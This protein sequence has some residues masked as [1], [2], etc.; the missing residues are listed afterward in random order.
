MINRVVCTESYFAPM[1]SV[2]SLKRSGLRFNGVVKAR[3]RFLVNK[4]QEVEMIEVTS[5]SYSTIT[6]T[7]CQRFSGLFG[8]VETGGNFIA[9]AH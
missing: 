2:E 7:N 1:N 4:L 3:R 9:I 5:W 6:Q 8:C